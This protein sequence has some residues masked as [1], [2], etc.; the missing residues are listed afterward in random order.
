M[1]RRAHQ[2]GQSSCPDLVN[3]GDVE[4]PNIEQVCRGTGVCHCLTP[5]SSCRQ[6]TEG[7]KI[8]GLLVVT[9]VVAVVVGRGGGA[10]ICGTICGAAACASWA[11]VQTDSAIVLSQHASKS[12]AEL[13]TGAGAR[14]NSL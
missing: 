13:G 2:L 8:T 5:E 3:V 10:Y 1:R 7:R 14:S 6:R 4:H 11:F 12:A 9:T